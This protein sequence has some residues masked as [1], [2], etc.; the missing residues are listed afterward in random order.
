[1][2]KLMADFVVGE[3]SDHGIVPFLLR[4]H[5]IHEFDPS[6]LT[7]N[8]LRTDRRCF[9]WTHEDKAFFGLKDWCWA[10]QQGG[11]VFS[12]REYP[13]G[14]ISVGIFLLDA[15]T[16]ITKKQFF[17]RMIGEGMLHID[18]MSDERLQR[19]LEWGRETKL[20]KEQV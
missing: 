12:L 4:G 10:L 8:D 6:D 16:A 14:M 3:R 5:T 11:R 1:M 7:L 15:Q 17:G 13:D 9:Y 2:I 20:Y 18:G 19:I